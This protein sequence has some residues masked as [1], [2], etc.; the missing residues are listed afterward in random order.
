MN[1]G[2][3]DE[4]EVKFFIQHSLVTH[5]NT[6]REKTNHKAVKKKA[7]MSMYECVVVM[8]ALAQTSKLSKGMV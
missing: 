6:K 5:Q 8:R 2:R 3:N 4:R 7:R 1:N